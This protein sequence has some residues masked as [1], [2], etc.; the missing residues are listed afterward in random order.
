M[1]SP[2]SRLSA[3]DRAALSKSVDDL[4]DIDARRLAR[5]DAGF[6]RAYE[7]ARGIAN[8]TLNPLTH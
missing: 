1:T 8:D 6:E 3:E 7:R 5:I 2:L 4:S